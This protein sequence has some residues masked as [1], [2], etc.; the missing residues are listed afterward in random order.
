MDEIKRDTMAP[1]GNTSLD[2]GSISVD[3]IVDIIS[4]NR[5]LSHNHKTEKQLAPADQPLTKMPI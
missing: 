1:F 5:S 2:E 4:L 3:E